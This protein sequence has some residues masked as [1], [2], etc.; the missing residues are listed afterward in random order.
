M[1]FL[2]D[3][4]KKKYI[5]ISYDVLKRSSSSNGVEDVDFQR[6]GLRLS[7]LHKRYVRRKLKSSSSWN[8]TN[9]ILVVAT[10]L[11]AILMAGQFV[12]D[13]EKMAAPFR[14]DIVMTTYSEPIRFMGVSNDWVRPDVPLKWAYD[15]TKDLR[16]SCNT[17]IQAELHFYSMM[18]EAAE[19]IR[20]EMNMYDVKGSV[21]KLSDEG[22]EEL[23]Y[24][25]HVSERYENLADLTFFF[26]A[27]TPDEVF[28][29]S[30]THIPWHSS[31]IS[32]KV[33]NIKCSC[34]SNSEGRTVH[35][36]PL[37][38]E[39]LGWLDTA[40]STSIRGEA[41]H[42]HSRFVS[43]LNNSFKVR[44]FGESDR[45][46]SWKNQLFVASAKRLR[47]HSRH[48]YRDALLF[49]REERHR[50]L[51]YLHVL[52]TPRAKE[53]QKQLYPDG[54]KIIPRIRGPPKIYPNAADQFERAWQKILGR[55]ES[56]WF[57]CESCPEDCGPC[58]IDV[59]KKRRRI[60]S[61]WYGT[62]N[63]V[64]DEE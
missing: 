40:T 61:N 3:V 2:S 7:R 26:Q 11:T 63:V 52:G 22:R 25:T 36:L 34:A 53:L 4:S 46:F 39:P 27:D 19:K 20:D 30:D 23:G 32:D 6:G 42:F 15:L 16:T 17:E 62:V 60:G 54:I 18:P 29:T 43:L 64:C 14:V 13:K 59:I 47:L 10:F 24:F 55:C 8:W 5:M 50:E 28:R 51:K 37:S 57:D 56:P 33:R 58:Y 49:T 48:A 45:T 35:W 44:A 12:S 9:G 41:P 31:R 21:T 38:D 1:T